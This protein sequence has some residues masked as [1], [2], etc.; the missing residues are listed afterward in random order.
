MQNNRTIKTVSVDCYQEQSSSSYYRYWSRIVAL[1]FVVTG[2]KAQHYSD[3]AIKKI[4]LSLWI[5]KKT[6]RPK[7]KK[8]R[9]AEKKQQKKMPT[10]SHDYGKFSGPFV[11]S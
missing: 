4:S 10:K 11:A 6:A 7:T 3:Y 1:L 9:N 5:Q 8:K 2:I